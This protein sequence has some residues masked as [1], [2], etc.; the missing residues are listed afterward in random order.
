MV[1]M[2][3]KISWICSVLLVCNLH[4]QVSLV[5]EPPVTS[6]T[7]LPTDLDIAAKATLKN[8]GEDSITVLWK[9]KILSLS[10]GWQTA[11]CDRNQC[12]TASLDS[13]EL[14]LA[15]GESSN[16]DIHIYPNGVAGEAKIEL[17]ITDI[18]ND[19]NKVV[20]TYLFNQTAPVKELL[21]EDIKLYPNPTTD[22][23]KIESRELVVKLEIYNLIGNRMKTTYVYKNKRYEVGDLPNGMYWVRLLDT[24]N[25]IVKTLR[26]NKR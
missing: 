14:K 19:S 21:A 6:A 9:R 5:L 3:R 16:M 11:V 1:K 17:T 4:A 2:L 26:L 20:G 22:Y 23:F 15:A 13:M 8:S 24:N 12:Y 18:A 25:K 10:A 7:V